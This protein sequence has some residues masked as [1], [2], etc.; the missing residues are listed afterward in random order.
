MSDKS[1]AWLTG[2]VLEGKIIL[3]AVPNALPV[4]RLPVAV[5]VQVSISFSVNTNYA[6][7]P[8]FLTVKK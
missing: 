6:S 7:N 2:N 4:E 3:Q 5:V 8:V 1:K